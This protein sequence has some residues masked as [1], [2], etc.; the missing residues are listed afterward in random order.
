MPS[1]LRHTLHLIPVLL[2]LIL[3][4]CVRFKRPDP[5]LTEGPMPLIDEDV[6]WVSSVPL[7]ANVVVFQKVKDEFFP[8]VPADRQD[9]KPRIVGLQSRTSSEPLEQHTTGPLARALAG[10]TPL[11]VQI[12]PGTY[13]VGVQ[14]DISSEENLAWELCQFMTGLGASKSA[15]IYSDIA[16]GKI[17]HGGIGLFLNDGNLEEWLLCDGTGVKKAGRTYEIEKKEGET[18]TVIALFQKKDENPDRAYQTLPE[19]YRFRNRFLSP[20]SFEAFEIPKNETE[21]MFERLMH[22][23]KVLYLD[24]KL[25]FMCELTPLGERPDGRSAGGFNMS[26]I[27]APSK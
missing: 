13:C 1:S 6:L 16:R 14:L 22:G 4:G 9:E 21:G 26:W 18:A 24:E 5:S 27:R 19:E 10:K 3:F 20:G 17:G 12:P 11:A 2:C 8:L 23:G 7:G 25:R 15:E